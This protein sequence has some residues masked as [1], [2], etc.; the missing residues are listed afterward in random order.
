MARHIADCISDVTAG[1]MGQA[2]QES[3]NAAPA[4]GPVVEIQSGKIRGQ[5][6]SGIHNFKGI[7][8]GDNTTGRN[9]FLPAQPVKA[10]TGVKDMNAFGPRAPQDNDSAG[11]LKWRDWIRDRQAMG[12]DCLVLNVYTPAVGKLGDRSNRPVMF[13]IHGGGFNSG[14]GS[15]PGIDGTLMAKNGDVVVVTLNH[16]LNVFGHLYLADADG[17]RFMDAGNNSILDIVTALKWVRDNIGA[18]G[19]DANNVTIFGQSGGAS[20]V[21]VLMTMPV[22]K[23]LFHKAVIQ[24]ASSLIRMAESADA[25]RAAHALLTELGLNRDRLAALQEVSMEAILAARRKAVAIAGDHFRPVIDGHN[26]PTHPFDPH[27]PDT[28]AHIPLLIGTCE[29]EATYS[30]AANAENFTLTQDEAHTR[31]MRFLRADA[32]LATRIMD[33]YRKTRPNASFS[34]ILIAIH[35]HGDHMYRRNDIRAAELKAEQGT[36]PAYMYLFTWK[37]PALGGILRT[38]HTICIPFVFGT[39]D[40]ASEMIGN[41]EDRHALSERVMGAWIAFARSGNPG[42]KGLPQWKP[43]EAGERA[44]MIFDNT[45]E[46]VNDPNKGDRIALDEAPPYS[47]VG[48][49]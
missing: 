16:R 13:Y 14:S 42:H 11:P 34:D 48:A 3:G 19:G 12:E 33:A 49:G 4:N 43:Y 29:T 31:V 22:A 36:A 10:W 17:G 2:V 24:S 23:G 1:A 5:V 35:I 46:L 38:P 37:S 26:L 7:P 44:T 39:V 45:C 27:A 6:V 30:M 15:V 21:A 18:F 32:A 8:Y 9:R 20:K 47:P 40:A 25:A 41:G 28:G